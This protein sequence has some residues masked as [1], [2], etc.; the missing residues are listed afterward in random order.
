MITYIIT[1]L[2]SLGRADIDWTP[3]LYI[4]ILYIVWSTEY[5]KVYSWWNNCISTLPWVYR[6]ITVLQKIFNDAIALLLKHVS[7]AVDGR[8]FE[9]Q[10]SALPTP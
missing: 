10:R 1:D 3:S 8:S 4:T 9:L 6:Y 5:V 7:V 2:L